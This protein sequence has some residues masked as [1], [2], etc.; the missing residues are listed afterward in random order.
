MWI[1]VSS[2]APYGT[3]AINFPTSVPA[4]AFISC[5]CTRAVCMGLPNASAESLPATH[6]QGSHHGF[7][8]LK[9]EDGKVI[10]VGDQANIACGDEIR[11]R[12]VFHFRDGSIDDET[13][14]FRQGSV[15]EL[16]RARHIPKGPSF[17]QPLDMIVNVPAGEVM[18]HEVKDGKS[19]VKTEHMDP[20]DLVNGMTPLT[21][22][23]FPTKVPELKVSYVVITSKPRVVKL[24]IKPD[25][26]DRAFIGGVGRR[27]NRFNVHVEIGGVAGVIETVTKLFGRMEI[28][29]G[30]TSGL[31]TIR[32]YA[33]APVLERRACALAK[34]LR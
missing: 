15:F 26:E 5:Q 31:S 30:A 4:A 16:V 17:P 2:D 1:E 7:L 9:S 24:S 32:D 14:T 29:A 33:I 21:V 23:N 3:D 19:E 22:E 28:V 10:A 25:G 8:L 12:L 34:A 27:A 13:S 20:S 18:W 11:S 6:K